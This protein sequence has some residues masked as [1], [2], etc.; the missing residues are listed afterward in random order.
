PFSI[1]DFLDLKA[2]ARSLEALAAWAGGSANLTGVEEPVALRAQWTSSGFFEL[3]GARASLGRT[4]RAEEERPGAARVVLL[5]HALW[6]ARFGADPAVL[7]RVVTINGEPFT[8]IGV[9]PREFPFL[10]AGADLAAPVA[11]ESDP[12]RANRGAG[13]LRLIGRLRPRMP[14]SKASE[15]L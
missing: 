13:F 7:G 15:E 3:V 8:V 12:R 5:G 10:A 2:N 11:Y 6:T 4:P 14:L 1:A 9:L